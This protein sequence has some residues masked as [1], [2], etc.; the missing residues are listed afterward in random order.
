VASSLNSPLVTNRFTFF[1]RRARFSSAF[2]PLAF[3][4]PAFPLNQTFPPLLP[5]SVVVC[6]VIPLSA[7]LVYRLSGDYNPLHSDPEIAKKVG[8]PRPILHGLASLG[9]AVRL[10]LTSLDP[11]LNDTELFDSVSVAFSRPVFPGENFIVTGWESVSENSRI[12]HFQARVAE[13]NEIVLDRG[14][15]KLKLPVVKS[16][17]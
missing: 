6:T 13:R 11:T 7:A 8:F 12:I 1:I 10:L 16:K 15:L 4:D 17:L 2:Q 9:I 3:S 5:P 14:T